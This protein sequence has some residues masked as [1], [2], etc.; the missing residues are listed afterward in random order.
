MGRDY[1]A[2]FLQRAEIGL[3]AVLKGDDLDRAVFVVTG[4]LKD[5]DLST[6]SKEL[7]LCPHV[8]ENLLNR[9]CACLSIG[10][11]SDKTIAQYRR[12]AEKLARA[13]GKNYTDMGV[14]DIRLFL[15]EEKQ[16]GVSNTTLENTRANLSAFFQW[17]L[18]E[19]H[20]TKNPLMNI[21]PIK[22]P[23]KVR[24]PYS[25]IE[26]DALRFACRSLKERAIVELLLSTGM[27]VSELTGLEIQDVNFGEMSIHVRHGK[28]AK[29]RTVY[30]TDLARQ[31]LRAYL[32]DR[33][34]F[35]GAVFLNIEGKP[36][37]PGGVRHV[38]HELGKRA[39]V[40]NVHPHR[41][42]RT[43]AT[44]LANRGMDIQ[45]IR[46]LLGHT[47]IDTTMEYVYT[48]DE[49]AHASYLRYSA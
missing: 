36:I 4:L 13:S 10:G 24:L 31:H 48:S 46:K 32:A 21:P 44:S 42:R 40:E 26:I 11:K 45:E 5:Y 3:A 2:E 25:T 34:A 28:G 14:Y 43:F 9:Y 22:C 41:F 23:N 1:K 17:L 12:T 35:D 30:M 15:A 29:E 47:N 18:Q 37:N 49:K 8:N 16:R 7:I 38:L 39:G 27:R 6:A 33:K 20:I 19:D